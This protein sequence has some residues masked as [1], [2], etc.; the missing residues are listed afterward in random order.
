MFGIIEVE[1]NSNGGKEM[2]LLWLWI[3]IGVVVL[4]VIFV[5]ATYNGLV[6]LR[7]YDSRPILELYFNRLVDCFTIFNFEEL[8]IL[9]AKHTC[10]HIVWKNLYFSV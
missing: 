3:L 8:T 1:L 6:T 7:T 2:E 4:L 9:K 5:W 10:N